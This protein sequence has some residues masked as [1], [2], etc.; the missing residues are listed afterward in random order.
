MEINRKA[1]LEKWSPVID[2]DGVK[3]TDTQRRGDLAVI[4]ENQA[5][6]MRK[7]SEAYGILAETAYA[8][9]RSEEHTSE[10]QS[11]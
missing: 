10:L 6:E 1:L 11:H 4:L 9:A 2:A 3:V 8:P 7:E 5:N